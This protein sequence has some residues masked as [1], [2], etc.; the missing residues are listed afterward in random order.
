MSSRLAWVVVCLVAMM[1][2]MVATSRADDAE[3]EGREL[4]RQLLEL[5][6][7][8]NFTNTGVL[9]VRDGKRNRYRIPVRFETLVTGTGWQTTYE[10]WPTNSPMR[11][12]GSGKCNFVKLLVT[13]QSG[14]TSHYE[15]DLTFAN[16]DKL[17]KKLKGGELFSPFANSDFWIV[18]LGLEFFHWP[19]Q[20]VLKHEMKRGQAC[21]VLESTN[22]EP[23]ADGYSRVVSWIDN[24][25]LGIVQAKGFDAKGKLLK[26]FAPK[27]FK[28][29]NGQ[30]QLQEMEI[31]N[32]QTGSRTR[33][34]FNLGEK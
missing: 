32:V 24:D 12:E 1:E 23:S 16:G 26:E 2:V 6:L 14:A 3:I 10:A 17:K 13:H 21:K 34:E 25:T 18:D 22:P 20:K 11:Y 29:I 4:V 33:L 28:K 8:E 15:I 27:E 19:K 30:W 9:N 7:T 31:R 5:H